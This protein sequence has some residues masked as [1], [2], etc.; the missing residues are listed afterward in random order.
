MTSYTG[1]INTDNEWRSVS[2]LANFIFETDKT[3]KMQIQNSAYLKI[4]KAVFNYNNEK[5]DYKATGSN[6][7]IKT[8]YF[9]CILTI[10]EDGAIEPDD[11]QPTSEKGSFDKA[12]QTLT[13]N[14]A[15]VVDLI[16][17]MTRER[18]EFKQTILE[19]V[20]TQDVIFDLTNIQTMFEKSVCYGNITLQGSP[21]SIILDMSGGDYSVTI[22]EGIICLNSEGLS[23]AGVTLEQIIQ[24]G[25]AVDENV[26]TITGTQGNYDVTFNPPAPTPS[27]TEKG[28]LEIDWS[29]LSQVG[30]TVETTGESDGNSIKLTLTDDNITAKVNNN[31]ATLY[32]SLYDSQDTKIGDYELNSIE[33]TSE[34]SFT[35]TNEVCGDI[36]FAFEEDS[37][38]AKLVVGE[39]D[40]YQIENVYVKF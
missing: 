26:F 23:A 38:T 22:T 27:Y 11:I 18:E 40:N 2:E 7:F 1:T 21:I 19:A 15:Y 36:Y 34:N 31:N 33:L 37:E 32:Y 25:G 20:G 9:P 35:V 24:M 14:N 16:N 10:L 29:P 5:F 3:Y 17:Q 39:I 4:G 12:S 13:L 6:L 30:D 8:G 28:L